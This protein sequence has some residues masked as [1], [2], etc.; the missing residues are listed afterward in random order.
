MLGSWDDLRPSAHRAWSINDPPRYAKADQ[1]D[2]SSTTCVHQF[3]GKGWVRY[4]Q[5]EREGSG[6][7]C[8]GEYSE[9]SGIVK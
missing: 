5:P 8:Q 7:N 4:K 6:I 3:E 2:V 1:K 9:Y